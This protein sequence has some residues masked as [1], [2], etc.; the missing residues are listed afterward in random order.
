MEELQFISSLHL[1][2]L[3]YV[4]LLDHII[5]QINHMSV[6]IINSPGA[7]DDK[8]GNDIFARLASRGTSKLHLN[9]PKITFYT[10]TMCISTNVVFFCTP[11]MQ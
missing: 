1:S 4:C 6:N 10:N 7:L 2:S 11:I 5:N 9:R 3:I 8:G